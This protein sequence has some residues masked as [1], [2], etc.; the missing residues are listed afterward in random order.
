MATRALSATERMGTA[1][2][3]SLV[4]LSRSS[5]SSSWCLDSDEYCCDCRRLTSPAS[6]TARRRNVTVEKNITTTCEC[7]I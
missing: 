4:R 5:R 1:V 2:A 3:P 7:R 6:T